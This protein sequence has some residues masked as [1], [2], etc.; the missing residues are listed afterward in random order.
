MTRSSVAVALLVLGLA[1]QALKVTDIQG[2]AFQSPLAGQW[3]KNV[4]GVVAAKVR[5]N[6]VNAG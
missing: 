2:V 6:F 3:V 5:L 1:A 4:V